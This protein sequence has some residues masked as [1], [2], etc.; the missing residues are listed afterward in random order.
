MVLV[1]EQMLLT[2]CS[3]VSFVSKGKFSS[4]SLWFADKFDT[5]TED[6]KPNFETAE[7][8]R[9]SRCKASWNS[10]HF[11]IFFLWSYYTV[12]CGGLMVSALV[13]GLSVLG[14]SP[15]RGHC[16]VFLG[17]TLNSVSKWAPGV[18]MGTS[19]LRDWSKCIGGGGEGWAGA[20]RGWVIN[21]WALGSFNFQLPVG[22]GSSCFIT[23]IGTHV[24]QSTTEVTSSSSKWRKSTLAWCTIEMAISCIVKSVRQQQSTCW[25][26]QAVEWGRSPRGEMF[27]NTALY[28]HAG[29]KK[30]TKWP[31]CPPLWG[32]WLVVYWL[33]EFQDSLQPFS[34]WI[35]VA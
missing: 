34:R 35:A 14:L 5:V 7:M 32:L 16:V 19:K 11:C 2:C 13:S 6:W 26:N 20:E 17:K 25:A 30:N 9:C 24:T 27:Q 3:S 22:M 23:E 1:V 31:T 10:M 8:I 29:L 21:S 33:C 15:G 28:R 18:E 4:F 12:L